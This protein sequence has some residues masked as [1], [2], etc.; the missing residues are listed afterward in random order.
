MTDEITLI[1]SAYTVQNGVRTKSETQSTVLCEIGSPTRAE[2]GA[3]GQQ[4]F[5]ADLVAR[6]PIE[7]YDFQE[8]AVFRGKMYSIYRSF[9]N[10]Q[11]GEAELYLERKQGHDVWAVPTPS[12]RSQNV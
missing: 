7:N 5:Q 4:G 3:A 9:L 11:T 6:T 8:Q 12:R 1:G 10:E 2:W